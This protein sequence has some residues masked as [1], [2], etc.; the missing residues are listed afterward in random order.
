MRR[1]RPRRWCSESWHSINSYSRRFTCC[2]SEAQRSATVAV[3]PPFIQRTVDIASASA[4]RI[5]LFFPLSC[6]CLLVRSWF[7]F[8]IG[9]L[10]GRT[11]AETR[12]KVSREFVGLILMQWRVWPLA[13]LINFKFVPPQLRVLTL[14]VVGVGWMVR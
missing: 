12:E 8:A 14:N 10:E 1:S 6:R 2:Q 7:F 9:V 11:L 13:S 4:N 5:F 3:A